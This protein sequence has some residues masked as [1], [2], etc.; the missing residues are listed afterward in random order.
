MKAKLYINGIA[1]ISAQPDNSL[2]EGETIQYQENVFPAVSPNYKEFIPLMALRRMSKAIKMGLTA[3]KIALKD[4]GIETPDAIITGTGEGCKQNTDKF[5]QAVLDQE[6][7]L[8][9]PTAFIQSTHNT[10]GGQIALDL[11]CMG[12]NMTYSQNSASLESAFID[13]QLQLREDPDMKLVLVGGVDEL[14]EKTTSFQYLD[15]QLK[16]EQISNLDLFQQNSAGTI[17][18]E[19]VHFFTISAQRTATTYAR[20]IDVTIFQE[21]EPEMVSEKIQQFLKENEITT[22]DLSLVILGN[23]GD[24]RYDH[25]YHHLQNGIFAEKP[26]LAYKHLTGEYNTVSGAAVWLACKILKNSIIPE[27]LKLNS[28]SI[29]N[30][31]TILIYNQYLGENHSLFLTSSL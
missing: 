12:Y 21:K 14:S 17:T 24:S 15:G 22:E 18:S 3:A 23:N 2:F 1:S 7:E 25:Y 13:A 26:Q 8:L 29:E 30:P 16:K 19:G 27:I 28:L 10:V 6:E 5:L 20:L 4:A 31:G 9:A 11:K